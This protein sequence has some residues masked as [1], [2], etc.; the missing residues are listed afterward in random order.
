MQGPREPGRRAAAAEQLRRLVD[1]DLENGGPRRLEQ[2][3]QPR[4]GAVDRDLPAQS[5][6]FAVGG[7]ASGEHR[8]AERAG[9]PEPSRG[10]G[11]VELRRRSVVGEGGHAHAG[12]LLHAHDLEIKAFARSQFGDQLADAPAERRDHP[13]P[14]AEHRRRPREVETLAARLSQ[15]PAR[16]VDASHDDL[17]EQVGHIECR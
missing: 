17:V 3:A 7:E 11:L 14:G 13:H 9:I 1:V 2:F 4:T 10:G 5:R 12:L 16:A 8:P 15:H 6:Q